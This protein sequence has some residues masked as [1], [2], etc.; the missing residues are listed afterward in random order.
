MFKIIKD[1]E[2]TYTLVVFTLFSILFLHSIHNFTISFKKVNGISFS[3]ITSWDYCKCHLFQEKLPQLPRCLLLCNCQ[4]HY[5][6]SIIIILKSLRTFGFFP[7]ELGTALLSARAMA[8]VP[9]RVSSFM[10]ELGNWV[11]FL[12]VVTQAFYCCFKCCQMLL[13]LLLLVY[14]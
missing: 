2:V 7:S 13:L 11:A 3:L 14:R 12:A 4:S 6:A 8:A 9:H 5:M 1:Q 10:A